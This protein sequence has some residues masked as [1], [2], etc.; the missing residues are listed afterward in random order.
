M[1]LVEKCTTSEIKLLNNIGIKI[2]YR[3]YTVE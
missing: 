1:N 2:E 3:E